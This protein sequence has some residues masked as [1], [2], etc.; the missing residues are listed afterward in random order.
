MRWRVDKIEAVVCHSDWT[1]VY[2]WLPT[3][4]DD[5]TWICFEVYERRR[6]LAHG[7]ARLYFQFERTE[8]RL[9]PERMIP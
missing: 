9:P 1:L 5:G 3:R 2:A 4:L 7:D 6:I 8:R